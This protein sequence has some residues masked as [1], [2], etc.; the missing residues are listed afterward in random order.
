MTNNGLTFPALLDEDGRV[1]AAY[2]IQAIPTSFLINR[3]GRII[4]RLV[5][6][7]N[8]DTEKIH[9]AIESLLDSA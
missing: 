3:D 5:G 6:S 4:L 2:G 7:I 1:S 8:W 9:A